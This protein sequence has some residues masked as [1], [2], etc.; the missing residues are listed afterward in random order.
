MVF[1]SVFFLFFFLPALLAV[2]Y[3]PPFRGRKLRNVFLLLFS[4]F[5]YGF[6]GW[7]LLPLIFCS[8][9]VNYVCG[10][11]T[12]KERTQR[13]RTAAM[14]AAVVLNLGLL[15]CFKYLGLV[16]GTVN[17]LIP[18]FPVVELI[19]PIGISFY[20]FQSLSYVIDVYRGEAESQRN[21]LWVALYIVFFPQLVAGPIVRYTTVEDE[22]LNRKETPEDFTAGL[23]RFLFGLGKKVLIANQMGQLA[24]TVFGQSVNYLATASAWL[25]IIG[26]TLQIYFDF[27]GYSDMAI[28]LGRMFGFHFAENFNYPY[29]ARSITEFWRRWHISLSTWFRDYLYIPLGG[30]RCARWKQIRN[31]FVVWALTGFWHGAQ[32][33]FLLW[34]LYYGI[35]IFCERYLWGKV[36]DRAP[37]AVRH[38]YTLLLVMVG[39][40]LFRA[41]GLSQ[42]SSYLTILFGGGKGGLWNDQTVYLFL[43]YRWE[44]LLAVAASMPLKPLA[45]ERIRTWSGNGRFAAE[46]GAQLAAVCIGVLSVVRLISSGFNPFIYFQF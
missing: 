9:V 4:L 41:S 5:F 3:F 1:S 30:N 45:Q 15:F 8:I 6:G 25:G 18:S 34:G 21:I 28:G 43:Q 23:T 11:L 26:Y 37:R 33:N 44:L 29:V 42:I 19:L 24:D 27:S 36:L 2:Y 7:R 46:T 32:W 12:A 10:R 39:W 22:I 17:A 38:I 14:W 13:V 35:L 20:T 31:L 40:V 16:T